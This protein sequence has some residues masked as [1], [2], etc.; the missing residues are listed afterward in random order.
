MV[1]G[2]DWY[3][4]RQLRGERID[5]EPFF[6]YVLAC[7]KAKHLD[8]RNFQRK[9]IGTWNGPAHVVFLKRLYHTGVEREAWGIFL[10][11]MPLQVNW[12][13]RA[14][15]RWRRTLN[16]RSG[17]NCQE[18]GGPRRK[19]CSVLHCSWVPRLFLLRTVQFGDHGGAGG[20]AKGEKQK[21]NNVLSPY[22]IINRFGFSNF[23]DFIMHLDIN[24]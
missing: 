11:K 2:W 18:P 3:V 8:R 4:G 6:F 15:T 23:I 19:K 1:L 7:P 16:V 22:Q 17:M 20:V 13:G 21:Q 10:F 5:L 14:L 24:I 9:N 12:T